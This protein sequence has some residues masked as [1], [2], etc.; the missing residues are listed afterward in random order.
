MQDAPKA[1]EKPVNT[2][3]FSRA[4]RH[5]VALARLENDNVRAI[6]SLLNASD[7]RI[8]A[9]IAAREEDDWTRLRL[10]LL[11]RAVDDIAAEGGEQALAE[12]R[13]RMQG[14]GGVEAGWQAKELTGQ[15][16]VNL[17]IVQPSPD[18][19][20]AAAIAR[21]WG[22]GQLLERTWSRM[23]D[24]RRETIE[25]VLRQGFLEGETTRKTVQRLFGTRAAGYK[26]GIMEGPRRRVEAIVRTSTQHMAAVAR[27][28]VY[29]R[30]TDVIKAVQWVA[31]LDS[32]TCEICG[33]RDG[34]TWA[35]GEGPRPPEHFNCRCTTVP[36]TKSWRE[37]G[38]DRDELPAGTRA[39]M[40]GQ[41]SS[42]LTFDAWLRTQ[43]RETVREVLGVKKAEMFLADK[44]PLSRFVQ[45][46]RV[47]TLKELAER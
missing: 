13:T 16:Q 37:M 5:A 6:L 12:L 20:F 30:N 31:T 23:F 14:L 18:Q 4:V 43:S 19:V 3:L 46:G 45:D 9:E 22:D 42:S 25:G 44:L 27:E 1:N 24:G 21:P 47:L 26:D 32:R 17:Q 38:I 15:M 28:Q 8:R 7:K 29:E 41:V 40:N 39:S 11:L 33:A 10:R 35:N 2:L 34:K 36:V